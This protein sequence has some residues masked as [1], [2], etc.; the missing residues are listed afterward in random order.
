MSRVA[1]GGAF[2]SN[3]EAIADNRE[4]MGTHTFFK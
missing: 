2:Q 1:E 3:G 4:K